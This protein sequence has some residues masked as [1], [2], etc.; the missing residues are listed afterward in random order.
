MGAPTIHRGFWTRDLRTDKHW[1]QLPF[2]VPAGCR[3]IAVELEFDQASGAVIDLGC[4]G[5][6]G[7]RGWSGGARR[8]Y[9]ITQDAAT[10]GYVPGDLEPGEWHVVLGLHRLPA[11]GVEVTV[12]IRTD[13]DVRSRR[14]ARRRRCRPSPVRVV[15][16]PAQDCAGWPPTS[17]HTQCIP[18]VR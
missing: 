13:A 14:H 17:M 11:S 18:T 9:V 12:T 2:D 15:S 8:S 7:W 10:P 1:P 4:E 3:S 6:K 5:A 16:P